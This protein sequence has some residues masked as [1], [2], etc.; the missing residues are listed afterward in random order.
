LV[1]EYGPSN[2][3]LIIY[4]PGLGSSRLEHPLP[5]N[6]LQHLNIRFI[7]VE[8]PGLGLSDYQPDRDLL[9]FAHDIKEQTNYLA[10][11]GIFVMGYS[12]GDPNALAYAH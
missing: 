6:L 3:R 2:G 8:R 7:S 4:F 10:V 1:A 12:A 11:E 5:E 9:D